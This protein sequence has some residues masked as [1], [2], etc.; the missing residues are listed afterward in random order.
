MANSFLD[1]QLFF[2]DEMSKSDQQNHR[3]EYVVLYLFDKEGSY[4]D[5]NHWYAGTTSEVKDLKLT[6][7]LEQMIS[8]LGEF[9]FGDIEVK[10]FQTTIDGF[11]F[12]LIPREEYETVDLDPSSTISFHEPW[13]GEYDTQKT[14]DN[15]ANPLTQHSLAR[16][17]VSPYTKVDKTK[18]CKQTWPAYRASHQAQANHEQNIQN[19][20]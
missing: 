4:L 15:M 10:P 11:S 14:I 13:Y 18:K 9:N 8:E 7:K 12:G 17:L 1:I 5:T 19:T 20:K 3:K 16:A 2:P 6:Q